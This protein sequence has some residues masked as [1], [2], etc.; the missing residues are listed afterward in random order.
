MLS[1]RC[2]LAWR[3]AH[4]QIHGDTPASAGKPAEVLQF[5][6]VRFKLAFV[7]LRFDC[8]QAPGTKL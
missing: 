3:P 7:A 2:S 8:G 5:H 1:P 4:R 6:G